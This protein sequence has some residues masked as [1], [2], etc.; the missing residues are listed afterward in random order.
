MEHKIKAL[1]FDVGG[2][3]IFY[4]HMIAA[5]KMSKVINVSPKRIFKVL[6]GRWNKHT[7]ASDLGEPSRKYWK[8]VAKILEVKKIPYKNFDN[9]WNTIFWPNKR[10]FPLLIKLRKEGYKIACISNTNFTHIRYILK[11]YNLRKFFDVLVFSCDVKTRKPHPKI[12][13]IALKRLNI[14]PE[15]AIFIDDKHENVHGAEKLG[16]NG[17]IFKSN[18]QTVKDLAKLGVK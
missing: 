2:V 13:K 7:V 16:I 1:I 17:I 5:K 11:K 8:I 12:Y 6:S 9:L 10:I 4:D 3:V 18:K 14:K 15:E